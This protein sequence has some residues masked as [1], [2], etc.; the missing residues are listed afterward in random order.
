VVGKEDAGNVVDQ[1]GEEDDE[2]GAEIPY[3]HV[4]FLLWIFLLIK[5]KNKR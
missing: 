3:E 2:D 1:Q 4:N 5:I